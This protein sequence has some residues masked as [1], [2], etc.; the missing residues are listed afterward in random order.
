MIIEYIVYAALIGFIFLFFLW[1]LLELL[2]RAGDK[3]PEWGATLIE[4][5]LAWQTAIEARERRW[6]E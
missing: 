2:I 4:L 3:L 1:L 6:R 5:W